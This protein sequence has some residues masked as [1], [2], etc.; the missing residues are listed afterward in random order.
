M[1]VARKLLD[2]PESDKEQART[3]V[4]GER[5]NG[6]HAPGVQ[7]FLGK[8]YFTITGHHWT[9]SPPEVTRLTIEQIST[10]GSLF[11]PKPSVSKR[12]GAGGTRDNDET[13][14]DDAALRAK[15]DAELARNPKLKARWGGGIEGLSDA[16]RS[17]RDMSVVGMLITAGWTKGQVRAALHLFEHGKAGE[18]GE[19]YFD[20]I[21]K[22]SAASP[23]PARDPGNIASLEAEARREAEIRPLRRRGITDS[24]SKEEKPP[25]GDAG[26]LPPPPIATVTTG[27]QPPE[28][29]PPGNCIEELN[30]TY[31][32]V[33]EGGTVCVFAKRH[34][35]DLGWAVY[36]RMSFADVRKLHDNKR[37]QI[38]T[39]KKGKP[40]LASL[41]SYW[42][43][44]K[45]RKEYTRGVT[46]DPQNK[47]TDPHTLNL[48]EGFAVQPRQGPWDKIHAHI[49]DILCSGVAS[50]FNYVL[51]WCANLVQHPERQGNIVIVL[52]GP[53]GAGKAILAKLLHR[54]LGP[55]G[56]I[57]NSPEQLTSKFNAHF[58]RCSFCFLDEAPEAGKSIKVSVL[59]SMVTQ[60][61]LM[62][63]PKN[64]NAFQARNRL[65]IIIASN[66]DFV[67]PTGLDSRRWLILK[68]LEDRIGD[69]AY[70]NAIHVQLDD[71]DCIA[72]A[73]HDLL[74]RKITSN[75]RI[76]PVTTGLQDH[77]KQSF[78]SFHRWW[79]H[80]LA[81]GVGEE[82]ADVATGK[83]PEHTVRKGMLITASR[84]TG[85][86]FGPL[87]E[88]RKRFEMATTL[89]FE[90]AD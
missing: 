81:R 54:I 49:R 22:R 69:S 78:K 16:S 64:V 30:L 15:L 18:E 76:A 44:H 48:W 2:L 42:L 79:Q 59:K 5:A 32:V 12:N 80:V 6:Q 71:D 13:A 72:A 55:H 89:A 4:Y 41:G 68:V 65:H 23:D 66:E 87:N 34:D 57:I 36:D 31:A 38:G 24:H 75:Q 86:S 3:R 37:V 33:N 20:R 58:Q 43:A 90:W 53:E 74:N 25:S 7:L 10:L 85:Y 1:P 73:L 70:F 9:P 27:P 46:Y 45:N 14:P 83:D 11:G 19:R 28:G 35:L 62:I 67:I 40:I 88:A 26:E 39:S 61:Y 63:E 82:I 17:G 50:I 52:T 56:V 21:W 29:P 51:D 84:P 47:H 60:D 8:R 77:R